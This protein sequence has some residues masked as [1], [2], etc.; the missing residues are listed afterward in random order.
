MRGADRA[1]G[2]G[3]LKAMYLCMS[4][5]QP[6]RGLRLAC[7]SLRLVTAAPVPESEGSNQRRPAKL[8]K[9]SDGQHWA[10][11]SLNCAPG[12]LQLHRLKGAG[13]PMWHVTHAYID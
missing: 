12:D 3:I 5:L 2:P 9:N 7:L 11:H 8:R 6:E 13:E 4:V 10:K 1:T